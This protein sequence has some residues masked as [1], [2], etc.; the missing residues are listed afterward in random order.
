[1]ISTETMVTAARTMAEAAWD[2]DGSGNGLGELADRLGPQAEVHGDAARLVLPVSRPPGDALAQAREF[3][4]VGDALREALGLPGFLGAHGH[5]RPP[6]PR[7]DPR[8]GRP[9]LRWWRGRTTLELRAGAEGP[10]LVL[11]PSS[12]WEQWYQREG[13][14]FLG[15]G[16]DSGLGIDHPRH[17]QPRDWEDLRLSLAVLLRTLPAETYAL[18]IAHSMP[19]YGRIPGTATPLLF[20]IASDTRLHLDFTEYDV[21]DTARGEH[22]AALGWSRRESLPPGRPEPRLDGEAPWRTDAGGPG[23]VDAGAMARLLVR[24]AIAAGVERPA[25]LLLGGEGEH[26]PPY[27][28]GFPGLGLRTV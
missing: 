14:G 6:G 22:A 15:V 28:F 26:R 23:E 13:T 2:L 17:E 1:M 5:R 27:E 4:R 3:R 20:C 7:T 24:T 18:G 9:F 25:D 12:T 10:E 11:E 21:A 8:W 16:Q 19:L